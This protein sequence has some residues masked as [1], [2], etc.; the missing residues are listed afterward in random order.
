ME[1]EYFY[2]QC[3]QK[4]LLIF[5][6][7]PFQWGYE[8]A[9]LLI[10]QA[11][12][13]AGRFVKKLSN[14]ASIFLWCC[15]SESRYH[16]YNKLDKVLETEVKRIDPGRPVWRNSVIM[17]SGNPPEYFEGLEEFEK[18][19]NS[20]LSVHWVG[21]YWGEIDDAEYY[22]PLFITEF[23]TQSVP[24]V[25]SLRKFIAE[26]DLWPPNRDEWHYRGFQT[27]IYEKNIGDYP[28]KLEELVRITQ[29][30]QSRFYKAHIEALRRKKFNNVNGLLQFHFVNT[31]PAIDW[32]IIDYYRIPK[33]AYFTVQKAFNP[34]LLSFTGEFEENRVKISVWV[35]NDFHRDFDDL[36]LGWKVLARGEVVFNEETR[37][38]KIYKNK[39]AVYIEKYIPVDSKRVVVQGTLY[40]RGDELAS[41]KNILTPLKD[42]TNIETAP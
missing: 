12:R 33:K 19:V 35:V 32:S 26:K 27:N 2:E 1:K 13:L 40:Q 9:P 17:A 29:E 38:N 7:L 41:N 5:Q 34:L 21:W 18:Y 24:Q 3:D 23:G 14:Y 8:P 16:D 20:H 31:W 37:I 39:A 11:R 28:D 4:G 6:D 25:E 36:I 22:N 30:Y 15:H 42:F 10:E